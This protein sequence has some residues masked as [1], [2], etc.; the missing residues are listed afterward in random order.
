VTP[1]NPNAAAASLG[2][3]ALRISVGKFAVNVRP[4]IESLQA[5]GITAMAGIAEALNILRRRPAAAE[6]WS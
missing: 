3:A 5:A 4:M 1:G 2:T 6:D